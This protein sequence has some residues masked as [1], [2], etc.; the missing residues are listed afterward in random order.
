MTIV[1]LLGCAL[2]PARPVVAGDLPTVAVVDFISTNGPVDSAM[3]GAA[4]LLEAELS[5][6]DVRVI[7]RRELNLLRGE[8]GLARGGTVRLEDLQGGAL[9]WADFLLRGEYQYGEGEAGVRFRL[10][11]AATGTERGNWQLFAARPGD[12]MKN[13]DPLLPLIAKAVCGG[14][15]APPRPRNQSGFTAIPEAASTFYHGVDHLVAGRPEYAAEYFRIAAASDAGFSLAVH[16]QA[17]AYEQLGFSGVAEAVRATIPAGLLPQAQAAGTSAVLTVRFVNRTDTFTSGQMQRIRDALQET[18]G[19]ALFEPDWIPALTRETDLKLSEDFPLV[20]GLDH[21]LW[22]RADHFLVF[23]AEKKGLSASVIN[24]LH[25]QLLGTVTG[26]ATDLDGLCTQAVALIRL[27]GKVVSDMPLATTSDT[28]GPAAKLNFT[29]SVDEVAFALRHLAERPK[30]LACWTHLLCVMQTERLPPAVLRV[31]LDAYEDAIPSDATDAADWLAGVLWRR[32][33]LAAQEAPD[34]PD[35]EKSFAPLLQRYPYSLQ[36]QVIRFHMARFLYALGDADRAR[37]LA[38]EVAE[39]TAPRVL[40]MDSFV[41]FDGQYVDCVKWLDGSAFPAVIPPEAPRMRMLARDMFALAACLCAQAGDQAKAQKFLNQ[42]RPLAWITVVPPINHFGGPVSIYPVTIGAWLSLPPDPDKMRVQ[43]GWT[44]LPFATAI[45]GKRPTAKAM[46]STD[47]M[48]HIACESLGAP[49][50][51]PLVPREGPGNFSRRNLKWLPGD[52]DLPLDTWHGRIISDSR[53]PREIWSGWL[54][55]LTNGPDSRVD[56]DPIPWRPA[57]F[58]LACTQERAE[59]GA[60]V[61]DFAV[62]ALDEFRGAGPCLTKMYGE[63]A[64]GKLALQCYWYAAHFCI[65][66]GELAQAWSLIQKALAW[67]GKDDLKISLRYQAALVA[68]RTGHAAE[69][70]EI[71][72]PQA[73]DPRSKELRLILPDTTGLGSV[74]QE[75]VELLKKVRAGPAPDG[76]A[77]AL[78]LSPVPPYFIGGYCPVAGPPKQRRRSEERPTDAAWA[79]EIAAWRKSMEARV[80]AFS[81]FKDLHQDLTP[82]NYESWPEIDDRL[83]PKPPP[84]RFGQPY[85]CILE[86]EVGIAFVWI[87]SLRLWAAKYELTEDAWC[88]AMTERETGGSLPQKLSYEASMQVCATLNER[89]RGRLPEGYCYRMPTVE[90]WERLARCGTGRIYPWGNTMPPTFGNYSDESVTPGAFP[91]IKGYNDGHAQEAPVEDSGANEWGLYGVGG[92]LWEWAT[93]PTGDTIAKGASWLF[94]GDML[95]VD[96]GMPGQRAND[97]TLRCILAPEL[98]PATPAH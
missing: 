54:N 43:V 10:V 74:Y 96:A 6:Y 42:A 71:L 5:R 26:G 29:Y 83:P 13:I 76:R 65:E 95:R 9:P 62:Q 48:L 81:C 70:A 69:A 67:R 84:P 89:E 18:H 52:S 28:N 80:P 35:I 98:K 2:G 41:P 57:T 23:S 77:V 73:E 60:A 44:F 91:R 12:L 20:H 51:D 16:A 75:A 87:D 8:R 39:K 64:T 72:R 11:D 97:C 88:Y 90:E 59:R 14:K 58:A 7:S 30:D 21:R 45:L 22:L 38:V 46:K 63:I 55:A 32:Y 79:K 56:T 25:G 78:E 61:A 34:M 40:K 19:F 27:P 68:W 3:L 37:P 1:I 92:N 49:E 17:K 33:F 94:T 47:A 36:A 93:T 24:L 15:A 53:S 86:D 66:A 31:F 82:E 85:V 4:D 50:V